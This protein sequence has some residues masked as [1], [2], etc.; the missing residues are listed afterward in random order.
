[1]TKVAIIIY[2][3]YG[4]IA[5]MAE[6]VKKGVEAGGAECTI[7]QV[8]ENLPDEV[9]TKMHAPPKPDYPIITADKMKEFDGFM[10]GLSGRYGTPPAQMKTFQDSTGGLWQEGALVG[11]AAGCFFSTGTQGGGQETLG[12]TS[13][14]FFA[15]HGMVFVPMGYVDPKVFTHDEVHGSSPYGCGTFAAADGSRQPTQLEKD[16]AV[17]HGK[18]FA[19]ITGKL[20]KLDI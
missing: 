19:T 12:L 5:T 9:L 2:S 16:V 8:A 18:H 11:K 10:F 20:V 1:M 13:V 3:L 4:H 6:S 15:H 14:P 7:F 17:S